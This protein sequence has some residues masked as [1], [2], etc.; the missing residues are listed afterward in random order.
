MQDH[1]LISSLNSQN[2]IVS[3][4][5]NIS[6]CRSFSGWIGDQGHAMNIFIDTLL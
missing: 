1:V 2:T 6:S 3:N 5:E 4:V